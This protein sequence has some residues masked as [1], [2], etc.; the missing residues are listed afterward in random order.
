[1]PAIPRLRFGLV[2]LPVHRRKQEN[3]SN[4]VV[5]V[6]DEIQEEC[7]AHGRKV[8]DGRWRRLLVCA[9]L[10]LCPVLGQAR[11]DEPEPAIDPFIGAAKP[12]EAPEPG[13]VKLS[14]H[15]IDVKI[16]SACW[17]LCGPPATDGSQ[18]LGHDLHR[19]GSPQKVACWAVPSDTGAYV[20][21]PVGGGCPCQ[22]CGHLPNPQCEGTWGWDYHG[23]CLPRRVFLLWW[24][25]PCGQGGRGQY[26][27]EGPNFVEQCHEKRHSENFCPHCDES[28]GETH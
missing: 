6:A 11:A 4:P 18:V 9:G 12:A 10:A 16:N 21:Y 27:P 22:C 14:G 3:S 15:H 13:P 24:C 8:M 17:P 26:E 23:R 28:V 7:A 1:M 25:K 20:G 5:P 2:E 19:A